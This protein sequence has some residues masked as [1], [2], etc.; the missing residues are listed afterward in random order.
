[1]NFYKS[2]IN[3]SW[4][5]YKAF[6]KAFVM[7][8]FQIYSPPFQHYFSWKYKRGSVDFKETPPGKILLGIC[9]ELGASFHGRNRFF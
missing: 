8:P 6:Y 7:K 5:F 4:S 2:F 9:V 1:M 3:F